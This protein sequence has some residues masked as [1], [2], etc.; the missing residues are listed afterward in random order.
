MSVA[1]QGVKRFCDGVKEVAGAADED[2]GCDGCASLDGG[3]LEVFREAAMGSGSEETRLIT[4]S[5]GSLGEVDARLVAGEERL[6]GERVI[7]EGSEARDL[8]TNGAD[9]VAAGGVPEGFRFKDEARFVAN[10]DE[11]GL[12][13]GAVVRG[14]ALCEEAEGSNDR[15]GPSVTSE[16]YWTASA[17]RTLKKA[18]GELSLGEMGERPERKAVARG[19][20][21]VG[22]FEIC[23][24]GGDRETWGLVRLVFGGG[25]SSSSSASLSKESAELERRIGERGR[26]WAGVTAGSFSS[27]SESDSGSAGNGCSI[28]SSTVMERSRAGAASDAC[29]SAEICLVPKAV[30]MGAT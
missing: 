26:F 7:L 23:S 4:V 21:V 10:D 28:K 22:E 8:S 11:S 29:W 15:G 18:A 3:G 16:I 25:W 27:A 13:V 2:F 24:D 30:D 17:L 20:A 12:L 14:G 9:L 19:A 6:G 5:A 1:L